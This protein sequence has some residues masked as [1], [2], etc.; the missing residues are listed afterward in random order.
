MSV[1]SGTDRYGAMS[2]V[3]H[4]AMLL[5]MV[6]V[7]AC[8]ELRVFYPKGSDPREALKTWHFMLG[9]TVFFLIWLRLVA[10][11]L[12]PTPRIVPNPS[13]WQNLFSKAMHLALYV[14]M[15]AMPLVGWVILSANG[16]AVPWFGLQLPALTGEDKAFA[17]TV[18]EIHEAGGTVGYF[19]IGLHAAGALFHH[20]V[21]RDN[22]LLRMLPGRRAG[23]FGA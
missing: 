13:A 19:L 15:I 11:V 3:L 20:Y 6:G 12:T 8:I 17:R 18:K 23:A 5:L 10:R 16:K 1:R 22:T 21:M 4:W 2:I 7:Y 14:F 9:L